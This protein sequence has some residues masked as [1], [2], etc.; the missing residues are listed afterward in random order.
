L[1]G[2]LGLDSHAPQICLEVWLVTDKIILEP[3]LIVES[4][5]V[6]FLGCLPVYFVCDT[7]SILG[8][9]SEP[10]KYS[11]RASTHYN[12]CRGEQFINISNG[13]GN[14]LISRLCLLTNFPPPQSEILP[15]A[16]RETFNSGLRDPEE[17]YTFTVSLENVPYLNHFNQF[18]QDGNSKACTATRRQRSGAES[19]LTTIFCNSNIHRYERQPTIPHARC[20]QSNVYRNSRYRTK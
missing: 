2:Q 8:A 7:E 13:T 14:D 4:S 16:S 15:E 6:P 3:A 9:T 5:Q 19:T 17:I 18:N 11:R 20:P 1:N 10:S 12:R